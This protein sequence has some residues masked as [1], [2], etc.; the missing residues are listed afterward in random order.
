MQQYSKC[1]SEDCGCGRK[2]TK[3]LKCV[4]PLQRTDH[5]NWLHSRSPALRAQRHE[6]HF[7]QCSTVH[8]GCDAG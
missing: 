5:R 7:P 4:K 1:T 2:D 8:R 3:T 6:L